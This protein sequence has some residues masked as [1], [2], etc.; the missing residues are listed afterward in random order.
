M[1]VQQGRERKGVGVEVRSERRG[2]Q[3][4]TGQLIVLCRAVMIVT[5]PENTLGSIETGLQ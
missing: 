4:C 3:G 5:S 1:W 2:I